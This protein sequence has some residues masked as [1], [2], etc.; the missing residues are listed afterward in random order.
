MC[1]HRT[2]SA[3]AAAAL[4]RTPPRLLPA[5]LQGSLAGDAQAARDAGMPAGAS[6]KIDGRAGALAFNLQG[7]TEVASDGSLL[8]TFAQLGQAKVVVAGRVDAHD[9]RTLVEA[10]GLDR[11]VSVDSRAGRLDFKASGRLDG[12]MA[13]TAQATAGGLD[14]SI[15]GTLQAAQSQAATANLMLSVVQANVRVPQTGTLPTT[16][17]A[18]A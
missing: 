5:K 18:G 8:A 17:T 15:S 4:R 9:G 11:L 3:P 14:V 7:V 10:V 12:P 2:A 13:A 6:F 1:V 16:L